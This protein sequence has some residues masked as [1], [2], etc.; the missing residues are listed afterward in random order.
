MNF[1]H[2]AGF[3]SAFQRIAAVVIFFTLTSSVLDGQTTSYTIQ[4]EV[5]D[6]QTKKSI[7]FAHVVLGEA[8]TLTNLTGQFV[9]TTNVEL[10]AKLKVSFMGYELWEQPLKHDQNDYSI[11]LRPS[12]IQLEEVTVQT[13]QELIRDVSNRFHLNYEV[14]RKHLLGYYREILKDQDTL[15]FI[16][17]GILDIYVPPDI[18]FKQAFV[19]PIKT[20]KKVYKELNRHPV[21]LK[22]NA[23]DMALSSIWRKESFLHPKNRDHYNFF[24]T[25]SSSIDGRD[26]LILEFEPNNPKGTMSGKIYIDEKTLAVLRLKYYPQIDKNNFWKEV[27]WTEEYYEKNGIFELF[28]V[29]YDGVFIL[30][31]TL[32]T[33]EALLVVNE[34]KVTNKLPDTTRLLTKDDSFFHEAEDDFSDTFWKGYNFMKLDLA[35]LKLLVN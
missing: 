25:E 15:Y 32:Y 35:S 11:L 2:K 7:P 4:G 23:C 18:A 9:L 16:A 3:I 1:S 5:R 8:I 12:T 27:S 6:A 26:V 13:G 10:P 21:F 33:Y 34:S 22:G 14:S 20:R 24:Y 31:E 17:E 30:D 28:R 29:S 19:N